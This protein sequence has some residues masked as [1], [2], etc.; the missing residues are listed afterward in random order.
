M[1]T[2]EQDELGSLRQYVEDFIESLI[3]INNELEASLGYIRIISTSFK[4]RDESAPNLAQL[5]ITLFTTMEF[6]EYFPSVEEKQEY[7][8]FEKAKSSAKLENATTE[9]GENKCRVTFLVAH[10]NIQIDAQVS[11]DNANIQE[12]ILSKIED[13]NGKVVSLI[14]NNTSNDILVHDLYTFTVEFKM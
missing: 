7:F 8:E 9:L 5:Y 2:P 1:N 6:D 11:S 3:L 14:R 4:T 10:P 13:F 12:Q